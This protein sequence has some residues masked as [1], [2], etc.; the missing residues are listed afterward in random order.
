MSH[1]IAARTNTNNYFLES[2]KN[3]LIRIKRYVYKPVKI[4]IVEIDMKQKKGFDHINNGICEIEEKKEMKQKL[5]KSSKNDNANEIIDYLN[6]KA[7]KKF[8]QTN[9]NFKFI[10]ARL[11]E[12]YS[13]DDLKAVIDLKCEDWLLDDKMKEYLRPETL[14]N[15]TKFESYIQKVGDFS[16]NSKTSKDDI[17]MSK[18]RIKYILNSFLNEKYAFLDNGTHYEGFLKFIYLRGESVVFEYEIDYDNILP[19]TYDIGVLTDEIRFKKLQNVL[20][21]AKR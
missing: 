16:S 14:F 7:S 3:D 10:N 13:V 6:L 18:F 21:K 8:K 12:G 5:S 9:A 17:E 2:F 11:K 1:T 15:A 20:L 19:I 4:D